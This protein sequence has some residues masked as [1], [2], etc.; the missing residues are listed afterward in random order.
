MK[1]SFRESRT[2]EELYWNVVVSYIM[3]QS[4]EKY[5]ASVYF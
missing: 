3:L 2:N 4:Y 1:C 5:V